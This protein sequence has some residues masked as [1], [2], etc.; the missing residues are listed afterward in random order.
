M[1]AKTKQTKRTKRDQLIGDLSQTNLLGEIASWR[2]HENR[3]LKNKHQDVVAAL[4]TVGFDDKLAKTFVPAQAFS[5]ACSKLKSERVIDVIRD[6]KDDILFQFSKR[7]ITNDKDEGGEELEYRKEA[8]ILLNKTTGKLECR[9][10][11]IK[12]EAERELSRC[13]EERTTTDIT[14]I[15]TKIFEEQADL[16][17]I[18]EGVYFVPQMFTVFTDKIQ[19]F[20]ELLGRKM[21]RFPVPAGT[22]HGDQSVQEAM[23]SHFH[24]LLCN[25]EDAINAFSLTTRDNTIGAVASKINITKTKIES[26]A[27][28]LQDKSK[29]LMDFVDDVNQR[30]LAKVAL[31][32]EERKN[33]PQESDLS[34][35]QRVFSCLN[36]QPKSVQELC[37]EAG[38]NTNGIKMFLD[39]Q[40]DKG[41]VVGVNGKYK[42]A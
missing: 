34:N 9:D 35:T 5:R 2:L 29:D 18:S 8:K 22:Q 23:D 37:E 15:V 7:Q 13:L 3:G 12:E 36:S 31:L 33:A 20:L 10:D 41:R 28:Y 42:I 26:Y 40:I 6:D 1:T 38:V 17:P 30:L 14:N 24:D 21:R 27:S 19:K 39:R 11:T 4:K 32:T 16:I 25:M